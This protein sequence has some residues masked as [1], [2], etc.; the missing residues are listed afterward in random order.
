MVAGIAKFVVDPSGKVTTS[1]QTDRLVTGL[2]FTSVTVNVDVID[3]FGVGIM[4]S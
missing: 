2:V 4:T 3:V 1:V